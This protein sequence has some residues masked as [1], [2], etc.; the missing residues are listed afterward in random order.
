MIDLFRKKKV[1]QRILKIVL[2]S[3]N[4]YLQKG[5]NSLITLDEFG[6]YLYKKILTYGRAVNMCITYL[7]RL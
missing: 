1:I 3:L 6:N 5:I 2:K 7:K 4:V